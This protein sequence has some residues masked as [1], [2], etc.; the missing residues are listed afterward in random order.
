MFEQPHA[1]LPY[2]RKTLVV[3]SL[4]LQNNSD[5]AVVRS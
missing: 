1:N 3:R 2:L 5:P 4:L